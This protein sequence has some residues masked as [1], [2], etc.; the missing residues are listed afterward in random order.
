MQKEIGTN[1]LFLSS[2]LNS[3]IP[4][5]SV[6]LTFRILGMGILSPTASVQLQST[7]RDRFCGNSCGC[8]FAEAAAVCREEMGRVRNIGLTAHKT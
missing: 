3:L 8:G 7:R 2:A 1:S 4:L 5:A 6:L